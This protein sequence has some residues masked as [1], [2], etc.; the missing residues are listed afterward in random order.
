MRYFVSL[1]FRGA[2]YCGWQIQKNGPSVQAEMERAFSI[3]LGTPTP[4]TGAGRT[5]TGVNASW[6][7]AHFDAADSDV[8]KDPSE[9]I[10][11]INAIL[12]ID[13]VVYDIFSV[14]DDAH[15]RFDA[16][17]RTYQYHINLFKEP[18]GTDFSYWFHHDIDMDK[19][20][21]A[22]Q[23]LIGEKDFSCFE[24]LRGNSS[25]SICTVT[26]AR[27]SIRRQSFVTGEFPGCYT[28]TIT[29]NR[30]LR[31]MVRAIVGSL[32]EIGRGRKEPGWIPDLLASHDRS[33][34]GQSVPGNAL[35]LTDIKYP[36]ELKKLQI[37]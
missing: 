8:F 27:W 5:D 26:H 19:M 28:F 12:P 21:T 23:Y 15:A 37:N 17:S 30:F 20:N 11:K 2:K 36:Y 13:I 31:N 9:L 33:A 22:A 10:Y 3:I 32:L 35:F 18:F 14:K 16:Y 24:K 1:S 7:I 29:A 25:S 34:A 4:V 6:F